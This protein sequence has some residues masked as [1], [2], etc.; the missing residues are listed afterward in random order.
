MTVVDHT[1]PPLFGTA[2][3]PTELLDSV[4]SHWLPA[5]QD[6]RAVIEAAIDASLRE[7]GEVHI[8]LVRERLTRVV[9]PHMLGAVIS[10]W[11][12]RHGEHIGWRRNGDTESGNGAKPARVWRKRVAS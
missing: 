4:A 7:V 11:A 3:H 10:A 6:D 9:Q 8:A 5:R 2:E 1:E 12:T